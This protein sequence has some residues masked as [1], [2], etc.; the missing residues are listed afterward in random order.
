GT[1]DAE[2]MGQL[3]LACEACRDV[4]LAYGTPFISGK[5]SL[6]NQFTDKATGR[7]IK[8]PP[9]LLISAIGIVE[10]IARC[11]T[12]DLKRPGNFLWLVLPEVDSATHQQRLTVHRAVARWI[13]SGDVASAHDVSDGG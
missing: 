8:I 11:C 7:V 6:H 2:A 9:T 3:V 13:A 4:A 10:D 12:S 1:D 5:D